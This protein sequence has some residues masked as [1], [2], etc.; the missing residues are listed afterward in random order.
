MLLGESVD[1][2]ARTEITI[3]REDGAKRA[4]P[5]LKD[6]CL[7]RAKCQRVNSRVCCC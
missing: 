2:C 6:W 5:L 7:S 3:L 4:A 1:D